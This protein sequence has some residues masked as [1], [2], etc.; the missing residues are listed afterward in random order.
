MIRVRQPYFAQNKYG[1]SEY[2]RPTAVSAVFPIHPP[3]S[4]KHRQRLLSKALF[5]VA[6]YYTL[7]SIHRAAVT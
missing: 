5:F 7:K 4:V 3:I 6:Y 1:F 2:R